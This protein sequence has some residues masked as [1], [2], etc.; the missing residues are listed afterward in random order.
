MG[1]PLGWKEGNYRV[2]GIVFITI[3]RRTHAKDNFLNGDNLEICQ[4]ESN[5]Y[6]KSCNL[7]ISPC[8]FFLFPHDFLGRYKNLV[9]S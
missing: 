8:F 6:L 9:S 1:G 4:D 2:L 3:F 7:E 5:N